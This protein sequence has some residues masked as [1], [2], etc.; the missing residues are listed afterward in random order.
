MLTRRTPLRR[1]G[2]L[3]PRSKK[4]S[5]RKR[6]RDLDYMLAVKG[7][8]CAL[9]GV[10]GAG[11]CRGPVEADHMG[12]RGLGQKSDDAEVGPLCSGHHRDRHGA[13]GF[14]AALTKEERRHWCRLTIAR[15]Q[16]AIAEKR[17]R[18]RLEERT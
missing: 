14:F 9:S 12:E 15:T 8:P 3:S 5:Y 6:P 2:R 13:R 16:H 11:P 4:N 7:L 17:A 10:E 18:A 1:G